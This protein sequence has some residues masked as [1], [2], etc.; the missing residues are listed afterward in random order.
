MPVSIA[1]AMTGAA[2]IVTLKVPLTLP[3]IA[4]SLYW[5]ERYQDDPAHAW[6]RQYLAG[7]LG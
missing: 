3:P 7:V 6:L 4:V 2:R 1:R 5:H